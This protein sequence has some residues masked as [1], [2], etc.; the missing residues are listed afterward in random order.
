MCYLFLEWLEESPALLEKQLTLGFFCLTAFA[1][2][3]ESQEAKLSRAKLTAGPLLC[4]P[5]NLVWTKKLNERRNNLFQKENSLH[6]KTILKG[7][8]RHTCPHL[9][10]EEIPVGQESHKMQEKERKL[11][12]HSPSLKCHAEKIKPEKV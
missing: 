12:C 4:E 6:G 1:T 11:H 9:S 7:S 3:L 2:F 5:I 10:S 8:L